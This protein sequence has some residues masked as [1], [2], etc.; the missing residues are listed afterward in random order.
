MTPFAVEMMARS[1]PPVTESNGSNAIRPPSTSV[2]RST[3]P[4][5]VRVKEHQKIETSE[6]KRCMNIGRRDLALFLTS[7]SFSAVTLSSPKPAEARVSKAE[8]KKMILEKLKILREKIGEL[9]K[10]ETEENE[11]IAL[12]PSPPIEEKEIS[13][14][15]VEAAIIP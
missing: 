2:K 5:Q 13:P 3:L 6:E 12:S 15:A 4:I 7:A 14:P 8:M 10:Q 1:P 11:K 9:S